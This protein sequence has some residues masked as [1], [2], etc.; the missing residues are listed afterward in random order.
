[1]NK[2][3]FLIQER[4][5][6]EKLFATKHRQGF[7]NKETFANWYI[8]QLK[9]NDFKCYYCE[10]SIFVV[11]ALIEKGLKTRKTGYGLR[12]PV[13]EIDRKVNDKGYNPSNCVLSCYYCN[14]DKSYTL[15]CEDY[16]EHFGQNR[17]QFFNFLSSKHLNDLDVNHK[18]I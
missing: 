8:E 7:L 4:K 1:M 15:E 6:V 13:L 11:R 10:T 5:R 12:G 14:N 9:S 3:E 2:E 16:K 18:T 17:K